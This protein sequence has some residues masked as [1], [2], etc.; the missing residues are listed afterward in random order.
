VKA[1][2]IIDLEKKLALRHTKAPLSVGGIIRALGVLL[3]FIL[4]LPFCVVVIAPIRILQP[5]LR[6]IGLKKHPV[7]LL[8][9][10]F[11]RYLMTLACVEVHVDGLSNLSGFVAQ[12]KPVL[13]FF[14]HL[15]NLDSFTIVS[16]SPIGFTWVAKESLFKVPIFGQL[17]RI[18][19]T[20]I[21]I[22]RADREGA[23]ERINKTGE[24]VRKHGT[25]IAIAPEGT[26]ST[27]GQLAEFKKGAFHLAVGCKVPI[28][29]IMLFGPY[30]LWPPGQI[31]PSSGTI[32]LRFLPGV[33]DLDGLDYNDLL[34]KVRKIMLEASIQ[35]PPRLPSLSVSMKFLAQHYTVL[36]GTFIVFYYFVSSVYNSTMLVYMLGFLM[37]LYVTGK[38]ME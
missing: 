4:F 16:Q 6:R 28:V 23:I 10:L 32:S 1:E 17:A 14:Q 20:M 18:F 24:L 33:L 26:R 34:K 30:D 27:S 15:S 35:K 37:G 38:G 2:E 36:F 11:A 13:G 9:N 7:H 22:D 8:I 21:G 3:G 31:L 5:F 25:S 12:E 29:P 19:G